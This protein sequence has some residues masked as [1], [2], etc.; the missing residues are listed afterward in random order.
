MPQLSCNL[1]TRA[2]LAVSFTNVAEWHGYND[3]CYSQVLS[4]FRLLLGCFIIAVV[5]F[6]QFCFINSICLSVNSDSNLKTRASLT[7][8]LYKVLLGNMRTRASVI[9]MYNVCCCLFSYY[10]IYPFNLPISWITIFDV[11]WGQGFLL[12]FSTCMLWRGG[13]A[14]H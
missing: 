5:S 2:S 3:L 7:F 6:M 1:K 8:L 9:Y 14:Y 4:T 12:Q 13:I 11:A 10:S